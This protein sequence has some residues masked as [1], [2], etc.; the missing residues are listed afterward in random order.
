MNNPYVTALTWPSV[1]GMA[2]GRERGG[3]P[4]DSHESKVC[5]LHI[6]I[7]GGVRSAVGVKRSVIVAGH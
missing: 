6:Y 3:F 7:I 1:E 4:P 2:T 5:R